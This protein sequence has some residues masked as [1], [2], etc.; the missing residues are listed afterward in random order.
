MSEQNVPS[1]ESHEA[2]AHVQTG[3]SAQCPPRYQLGGPQVEPEASCWLQLQPPVPCMFSEDALR[4]QVC[5]VIDR[6]ID[7]DGLEAWP[8]LTPKN[9]CYPTDPAILNTELEEL[10]QLARLRDEPNQISNTPPID[11]PP[12]SRLRASGCR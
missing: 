2:S 8:G 5:E 1:D 9:P 4:D 7:D 11:T 12:S 6:A 3:N 10:I